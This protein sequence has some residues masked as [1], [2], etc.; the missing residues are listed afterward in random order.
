MEKKGRGTVTSTAISEKMPI[1]EQPK[2]DIEDP[3][4][5]P[6]SVSRADITLPPI[7]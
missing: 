3:A 1:L 5:A 2:E 4:K 6:D 7:K